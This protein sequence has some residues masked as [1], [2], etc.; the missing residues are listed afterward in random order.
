MWLREAECALTGD[1]LS[2]AIWEITR[3]SVARDSCKAWPSKFIC[4]FLQKNNVH[5]KKCR[6]FDKTVIG[7]FESSNQLTLQMSK[8]KT[9][10]LC[11]YQQMQRY[12]NVHVNACATKDAIRRD[13][14]LHSAANAIYTLNSTVL[15]V[16][17]FGHPVFNSCAP[18]QANTLH[19]SRH[20]KKNT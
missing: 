13:A 14:M 7:S 17:D 12:A 11:Q 18:S 10:G 19:E 6:A 9:E 15:V 5:I 3:R 1:A 4:F 8:K 2:A 16:F 20:A